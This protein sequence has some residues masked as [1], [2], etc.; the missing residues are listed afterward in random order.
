M[1][2]ASMTGFAR[3][4]GALGVWRWTVE[5]K[6]VNA[7]GLDLRLRVPPGFDRIEA[8]ARARLGK[9]LS[10]GTVFANL[11]AAREGATVTARIDAALL[12][13][14]AAA[15]RAAAEKFGLAPPTLDGLLAV[16]GVVEAVE[17]E[18]DEP[19]RAATCDAMLATF[20]EAITALVAMRRSEGEALRKVLAERLDAIA[21]LTQAADDNPARRPDAVRAR[22]AASVAALMG[23]ARGLDET[24]LHQEA[25]L[26]AGKADIREELDRLH[27]HVAAARTLLAQGGPVGRKLDFL[28]QEFGR[29]ANTLCAK[30]N[31]ASLTGQGLELRAQIEQMREQVQNIE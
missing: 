8:E 29:E 18:D 22:L 16:R 14:V 5:I 7:K 1:T 23:A 9:A 10:R 6:C 20:D 25:I 21:A 24:R 28:A 30:S 26:I 13:E 3:A 12:A 19:T 4:Q 15:A 31:D 27:T 11:T 2:L 17:A